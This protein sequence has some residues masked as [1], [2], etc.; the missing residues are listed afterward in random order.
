[1]IKGG[2]IKGAGSSKVLLFIGLALGAISALLV[3][4]YL[5]Q[6]EGDGGGQISGPSVPVVVAAQ[7][8]SAGTR[9][10][11]DMVSVKSIPE[12]QVLTGAFS[13]VEDV[14]DQTTVVPV[15]AGEQIILAKLTGSDSA[16]SRYG[17][18]PP[19][20]LVV[21]QGSRAVAIS[22]SKPTGVGGL[23]RPGD[24][25][26]IILS[27][28]VEVKLPEGQ[29]GKNTLARTIMQNVQ[30]VALEQDVKDTIV[31]EEGET[32]EGV[33]GSEGIQPDATVATVVVSP[34]H[35]EVLALA[36]LCKE[37]YSG[38]L[39]MVLRGFGDEGTVG[40][41]TTYPADGPPPDCASLM[42]IEAL[43]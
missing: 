37:Q 36:D 32:I 1:M 27:L 2:A 23:I 43:P 6:A 11:S 10:T 40:G 42:G 14:V 41:R 18:D 39:T 33:P 22:V 28:Q 38:R 26:D 4:V 25:V 29:T 24:Y 9:I 17:D 31:T 15:V 16:L 35:A 19:L 8:I 20:S 21:P 34:V 30:V 3:F 5:S 7:D 12:A 13:A